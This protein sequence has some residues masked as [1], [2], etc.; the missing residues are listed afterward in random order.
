VFVS[1]EPHGGAPLLARRPRLA[2]VIGELRS[3]LHG[4]CDLDLRTHTN[5]V[6][7]DE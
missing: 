3:A 4:I 2:Q 7:L 1:H 5:G 6:L